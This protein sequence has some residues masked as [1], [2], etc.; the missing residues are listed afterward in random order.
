MWEEVANTNG[1]GNNHKKIQIWVLHP[2]WRDGGAD[3]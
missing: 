3:L 1:G 2:S